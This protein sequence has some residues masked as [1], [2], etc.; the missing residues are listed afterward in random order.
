LGRKKPSVANVPA[1][2][3]AGADRD[4]PQRRRIGGHA[5]ANRTAL[6]RQCAMA[7]SRARTARNSFALYFVCGTAR[8]A[9]SISAWILG[10]L[11]IAMWEMP[12]SPPRLMFE[13]LP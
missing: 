11:S 7:V 2:G 6:Q 10:L 3:V 9:R 12:K 4:H 5:M 8:M 1:M 13:S